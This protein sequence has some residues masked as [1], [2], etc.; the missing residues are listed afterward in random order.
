MRMRVDLKQRFVMIGILTL[1]YSS[2]LNYGA[3]LQAWALKH[4][5]QNNLH[6]QVAVLPMEQ[7]K[8]ELYGVYMSRMRYP[9]GTGLVNAIRRTVSMFKRKVKYNR[10]TKRYRE[11]RER[12]LWF[13]RNF[14]SEGRESF[15]PENI[16]KALSDVSS[17]VVGSDWVWYLDKRQY[18]MSPDQLQAT[19]K[20][21]LGFF[22]KMMKK[23]RLIS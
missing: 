1:T 9:E 22:P 5:L 18:D 2:N 4:Y 21:Y 15:A 10:D 23:R 6:L 11:R 12:F 13:F 20:I 8:E 7:S 3:Q 19:K 14:C 17:I 16:E